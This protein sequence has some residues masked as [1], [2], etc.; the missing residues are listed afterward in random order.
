MADEKADLGV[1][2]YVGGPD[3]PQPDWREEDHE[4][5]DDNDDPEPIPRGILAEI[6]GFNPEELD[7]DEDEEAEEKEED[8]SDDDEF[9][10]PEPDD[11]L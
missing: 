6:L 5:E 7:E 3:D 11:E 1:D 4:S 9:D 2:L 8:E 10:E